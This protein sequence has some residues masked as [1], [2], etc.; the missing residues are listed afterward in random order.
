ME[1][2]LEGLQASIRRNAAEH[3]RLLTRNGVFYATISLFVPLATTAAT[4]MPTTELWE[5]IT[6][7]ALCGLATFLFVLDR[8]F[9]FGTRWRNHIE[10]R[11]GY[12]A[13]LAKVS[14]YQNLPEGFGS[15][16]KKAY[17]REIFE[18]ISSLSRLE[19]EIPRK[20]GPD[21]DV[22]VKM[23]TPLEGPTRPQDRVEPTAGEAE[24]KEERVGAVS[25]P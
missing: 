3:K 13:V 5:V 7:K 10:M 24:A 2:K 25:T 1:T 19:G 17:Y 8:T 12:E 16:D 18:E 14:F 9:S 23:A 6:F 15:E 4:L 21:A 22:R 11:Y 20:S